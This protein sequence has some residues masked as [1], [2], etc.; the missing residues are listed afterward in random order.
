MSFGRHWK[1]LKTRALSNGRKSGRGLSE[2]EVN[3][4]YF[5]RELLHRA[6]AEQT[7][8]PLSD[9][10]LTG[11]KQMQSCYDAAIREKDLPETFRQNEHFH[12]LLNRV[13]EQRSLEDALNLGNERTNLVRSFAFRSIK[14]LQRS[15][16][17]HHDIIDAGALADR[18]VFVEIILKHIL[19]AKTSYVKANFSA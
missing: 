16:K 5:A 19:G 13:R 14:S 15:A 12:V 3:K 10:V 7:R 9:E 18:N 1:S 6:A 11:L 4:P 17:E 8:P 2:C